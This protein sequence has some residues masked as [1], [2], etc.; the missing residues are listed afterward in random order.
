MSFVQQKQ[1]LFP[2]HHAKII[3]IVLWKRDPSMLFLHNSQARGSVKVINTRSGYL[4]MRSEDSRKPC[5]G[6]VVNF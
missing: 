6:T 3:L 5:M 4:D 2:L 1:F